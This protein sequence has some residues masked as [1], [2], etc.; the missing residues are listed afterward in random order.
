M[1][2]YEAPIYTADQ[3]PFPSSDVYDELMDCEDIK[4]ELTDHSWSDPW[5]R[6]WPS[7]RYFLR[8]AFTWSLRALLD[9]YRITQTD[10]ARILGM[11]QSAVSRRLRAK[12]R[13]TCEDLDKLAEHV[14]I[15][16]QDLV[17]L[18]FPALPGL[19]VADY[20]SVVTGLSCEFMSGEDVKAAILAV[21]ESKEEVRP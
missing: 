2:L 20:E 7:R 10:L 9:V 8:I 12:D 11:T 21:L 15:S 4:Y 16:R 19:T 6:R 17:N 14:G 5:G 3:P 1:K 18:T 13:F